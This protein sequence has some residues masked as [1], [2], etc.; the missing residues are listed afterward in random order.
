MFFHLICLLVLCRHVIHNTRYP[1]TLV[2][3][4]FWLKHQF[5]I[6]SSLCGRTWDVFSYIILGSTSSPQLSFNKRGKRPA[7]LKS[8]LHISPPIIGVMYR[9]QLPAITFNF[10]IDKSTDG[11][12]VCICVN[13]EAML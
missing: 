7:T 10:P 12:H 1:F 4:T 8:C 5:F 9:L 2:S 6:A 11:Q 3:Y 13:L